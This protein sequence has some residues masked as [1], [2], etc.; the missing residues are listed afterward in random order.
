MCVS[1]REWGVG[2]GACECLTV[3]ARVCVWVYLSVGV[4][5][6]LTVCARVYVWVYV[7]VCVPHCVRVCMCVGVFECGCV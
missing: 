2:R 5:E 7:S 3:C 4:F 6:C 1:V